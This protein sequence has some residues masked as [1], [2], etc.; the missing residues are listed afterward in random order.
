MK[1]LTKVTLLAGSLMLAG[2]AVAMDPVPS[3]DDKD[4]NG[5]DVSFEIRG[6]VPVFCQIGL[7][8]DELDF[9]HVVE[10]GRS[11]EL[12]VDLTCNTKAGADVTVTPGAGLGFDGLTEDH[13][14][15][16]TA[17]L[18]VAGHLVESTSGGGTG[19]HQIGGTKDLAAG[20]SGTLTVTLSDNALFAGN[21]TDT[22]EVAVT[23]R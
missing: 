17:N 23:A 10:A 12:G 8:G 5:N 7:D 4:V 1:N 18:V 6:H 13:L 15:G 14:V 2:N 9:E 22:I 11:L 16:Y 20:E 21:Y 19:S 3:D